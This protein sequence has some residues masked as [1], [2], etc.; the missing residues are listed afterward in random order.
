[1]D[2]INVKYDKKRNIIRLFTDCN[3]LYL[4]HTVYLNEDI[5]LFFKSLS[6]Q[7]IISNYV[8]VKSTREF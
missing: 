5:Y 3:D 6:K 2:K 4:S 1:M 8:E 7:V